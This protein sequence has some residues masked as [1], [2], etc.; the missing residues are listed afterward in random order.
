[1]ANEQNLLKPDDLTP[2]QRRENASKAGKASAAARQQ[3]KTL[4][5]NM[6]LLLNMPVTNPDDWNNASMMGIQPEEITN[7]QLLVIAMFREAKSGNVNAFKEIRAMIG[8]ENVQSD[9]QIKKLD[10]VLEQIGGVI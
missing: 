1:M 2:K 8:E 5:E 10:A 7:A 9:E 3:R 4:A 6:K